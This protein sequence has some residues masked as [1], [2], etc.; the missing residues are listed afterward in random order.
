MLVEDNNM[1]RSKEFLIILLLLQSIICAGREFYITPDGETVYYSPQPR[2]FVYK[3]KAEEK[4]QDLFIHSGNEPRSVTEPTGLFID[5]NDRIY[6]SDAGRNAVNVF[7]PR[8]DFLKTMI[9][10]TGDSRAL[11]RPGPLAMNPFGDLFI[12]DTETRNVLCYDFSGRLISP[13]ETPANKGRQI[14]SP[15][16]IAI[17]PAGDIFVADAKK[18]RILHFS[19]KRELIEAWGEVGSANGQ[20]GRPGGI[21]SG[22]NGELYVADTE[23]HRVQVF[24]P[25]GTFAYFAEVATKAEKWLFGQKG[26]RWGDFSLP[27]SIAV[28]HSGILAVVD[29]SGGR[30]QLFTPLGKFRGGVVFDR[31]KEGLPEV[32]ADAIA[33]D[34]IGSLYILDGRGRR[35]LKVFPH[36]Q[37]AWLKP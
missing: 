29:S 15:S 14:D 28:N 12:I 19:F 32:R 36:E 7:S 25:D 2:V 24:Q 23:N 8:G 30:I 6:I 9:H 31:D 21:A 4:R 13:L 37:N 26:A 17:T 1:R 27:S 11:H 18:C 35:I 5:R 16:A 33:F 20:L 3:P 10:E 34:S 22:V